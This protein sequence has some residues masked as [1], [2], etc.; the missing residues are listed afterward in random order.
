M[1]DVEVYGKLLSTLPPGDD[2]PY[3][4]GAWRPQNVEYDAADLDVTGELPDDLYGVYLRNTE[5]PLHPAIV[6]YHP[7]DGDGMIHKVSFRDGRVSYA[8]RFVRTDGLL[9]EQEAGQSLWA[10]LAENPAVAIRPDGRGARG[11]MKDAA[12]TDIIVHAGVAVASFYQCGDLYRLDPLTLDDLGKSSFG[13]SFPSD[14]GVSAHTKVDDRTGELLFFNYGTTAPYLHY[15]V[16]DAGNHLVHY[17][18]IELPGPRLP[19]DMAFT[20]HYAILN[21][22]PLFWEPELIERGLYAARYHPDL[23]SRLGVIPRRGASGDIRWFEFDPTYVLHWTNAYEAGDEII[24]EGFFQGCPEPASAGPGGPPGKMFRFLAQDIM[25]TRLHRWRINLVTGQTSEEDLSDS[26]TEFGTISS[27]FGGQPY[28]YTYAATNE[29]GWFLFNGLVK[30]DTLTG[31]EERYQFEPG[32]FCSEAGVAPRA[33][34]PDEDD[35][36][37]VTLTTDMNRDLSE[38]VV[39]R[40]NDVGR[41]PVARARLPERIASGTHSCWAPGES[42]RGW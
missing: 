23:P 36:Y 20:E 35:A 12:S 34:G 29:P 41:G 24:V 11:R 8:N 27:R 38:C 30:H 3:R 42:V 9:A 28:R 10:G 17:V 14:R 16:V 37:L 5:N 2:H 22:M 6:R 40:A 7:F 13:G 39:F 32:V 26:C 31:R 19:H 33:G 21:D 4:S 18:P 25:Q 1:A 15:G